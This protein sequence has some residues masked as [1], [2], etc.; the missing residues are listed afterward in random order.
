M[1]FML[2]LVVSADLTAE[3]WS[4]VVDIFDDS[5]S[6][7]RRLQTWPHSPKRAVCSP[8]PYLGEVPSFPEL[9]TTTDFTR[10]VDACYDNECPPENTRHRVDLRCLTTCFREIYDAGKDTLQQTLTKIPSISPGRKLP[11]GEM[12]YRY[13]WV[14]ILTEFAFGDGCPRHG[15]HGDIRVFFPSQHGCELRMY[16]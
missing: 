1:A 11:A 7:M 4:L 9:H 5:A 8:M 10:A 14:I 13:G 15:K 2:A 16:V 6:R 3:K 12:S